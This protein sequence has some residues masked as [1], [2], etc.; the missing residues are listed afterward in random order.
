[1]LKINRF[2]TAL[3]ALVCAVGTILERKNGQIRLSENF[4]VDI[5]HSVEPDAP[6]DDKEMPVYVVT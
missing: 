2:F 4:P 5:H 1:M 6:V 3:V